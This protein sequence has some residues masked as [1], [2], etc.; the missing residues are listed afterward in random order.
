MPVYVVV[1][2]FFGDEGKGKVVGY[3]A[4]ADD[5]DVAARGGVGPNAGHT[6]VYDTRLKLRQI[7][8]AVVNPRARLLI[9]PGVLVN[10]KVLLN[11]VEL[12]GCADRLGVDKNAGVIEERHIEADRGS[13][14]LAKKIGTTGTGCGPAQAD[15]VS[16]VLKLARDV[17]ELKPFLVDSVAELNERVKRGERVLIEGTQGTFLS[18]YHGTYPYVTSKDVTASAVCAD[19]GLGPKA[20]DEVVVVFKSYVTRVGEGPLEN[21]LPREEAEARG[22]LEIATVTGRVRRVA[23]FSFELAKRAVTIN[24]ATQIALTK[25][26]VVFKEDA[27][28]KDWRSL[29]KEAKKFIERIEEETR[30]PVTLISTGE[31]VS[32]M[33]DLRKEKGFTR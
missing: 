22:W 26:D 23:P 12:T 18:L 8:S 14:H 21:E 2:G 13:A 16:R 4:V 24:S 9:G 7:P 11:E 17:P 6:V 31:H 3:L 33:I 10:P 1:G 5:V 30:V 19:V 29:S 25:V 20:V 32:A 27:G 15:R 28:K